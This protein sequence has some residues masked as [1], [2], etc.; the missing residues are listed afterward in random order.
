MARPNPAFGILTIAVIGI[1]IVSG[2]VRPVGPERY[3]AFDGTLSK[4]QF[5]SRL[6]E[7]RMKQL[8]GCIGDLTDSSWRSVGYRVIGN[9]YEKRW[10]KG[11]GTRED[12][13]ITSSTAERKDQD[14]IT[15]NT[16]FYTVGGELPEVF[17]LGFRVHKIPENAGWGISFSF[18]ENGKTIEGEQFS[19][20]F[21]YFNSSSEEPQ[22]TVI[23][24]SHFG[25]PVYE[26]SVGYGSEIPLREDL[27]KYLSS[28]ESMR[29][30]GL[31]Q[32]EAHSKRVY[33][34]IN[35]GEAVRC[36]YGPY[37]GGGIPP[38]CTERPLTEGERKE[39]LAKAHEYF[40]KERS[41]LTQ[42]YEE[43]YRELMEAFP[44]QRC[45]E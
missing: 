21:P 12:C 19:M 44:F 33:D 43:I 17:G 8:D 34:Y 6:D 7:N 38:K 14:I 37:K 18:D 39:S 27:A 31:E 22:K 13:Q 42:D 24:G 11:A 36:E 41:K 3:S 9:F 35:S 26:K 30:H 16:L 28:A 32:L 45:W 5:E 4:L 1:I 40:S 23:L 2:C 25:Y 10:C 15:L 20:I 29:D